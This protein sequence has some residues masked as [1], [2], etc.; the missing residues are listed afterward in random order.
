MT[1]D[2]II[3][4]VIGLEGGFVDNAADPGGRTQWGVTQRYLNMARLASPDLNLPTDVADL[5]QSQAANLYAGDQWI[6]VKGDQLP[7]GLAL[8][9]F[10]TCVNE[11]PQ[12]AK[13]ILQQSLGVVADGIVGSTTLAAATSAGP[14]V[15]AEFAARRAVAYAQLQATEG[16][17]ELGWM[18]RL[19]AVYTRTLS[20]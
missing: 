9:A 16:Q 15:Y 19:L 5:S 11:G 1:R 6:A 4:F 8:Q 2:E 12:R 10:D 3:A 20:P 17:F 7:W 18:R 14:K 13:I